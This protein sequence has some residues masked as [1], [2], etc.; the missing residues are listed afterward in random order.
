M[1]PHRLSSSCT[2]LCPCL[3]KPLSTCVSVNTEEPLHTLLPRRQLLHMRV[4]LCVAAA[5]PCPQ[6]ALTDGCAQTPRAALAH[7]RAHARVAPCPLTPPRA[8]VA[9]RDTAHRCS[10]AQSPPGG[11][12]ARETFPAR[13]LPGVVVPPRSPPP[14]VSVAVPRSRSRSRCGGGSAE[15]AHSPFIDVAREKAGGG[16]RPS[17]GIQCCAFPA[18]GSGLW[19]GR[20]GPR[21]GRGGD[22]VRVGS[23]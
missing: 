20:G 1:C 15:A 18:R 4:P 11:G 10:C 13:G 12:V 23:V 21:K 19:W 22:G 2:R 3:W 16:A 14:P 7:T 17:P 9:R 8:H 6:A 5:C